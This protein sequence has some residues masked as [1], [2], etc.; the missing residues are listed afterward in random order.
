MDT[1][2]LNPKKSA[3]NSTNTAKKAN[4]F[5]EVASGAKIV[6]FKYVIYG[7]RHPNTDKPCREQLDYFQ[8]IGLLATSDYCFSRQ[9]DDIGEY[10]HYHYVQEALIAQAESIKQYI[11]NGAMV[12]VCGSKTAL[13]E[14]IPTTLQQCLGDA[15]YQGLIN[16]NG[17][18]LDVY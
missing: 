2:R 14:S 3:K 18:R 17:L 16:R 8:E 13:G 5:A 11:N 7:E 4:Q 1:G 12:Y 6:S 10:S 15:D 9:D